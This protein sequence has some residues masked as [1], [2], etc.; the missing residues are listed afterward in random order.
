[1]ISVVATLFS[2]ELLRKLGSL[3]HGHSF[4][5]SGETKNGALRDGTT[6]LVVPEGTWVPG[7]AVLLV[8]QA[9]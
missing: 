4:W 7:T 1:M 2:Y 3:S 8:S 5:S 6:N 9:G